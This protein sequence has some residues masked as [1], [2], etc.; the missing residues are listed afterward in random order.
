MRGLLGVLGAS[1]VTAKIYA[2]SI[3]ARFYA[4]WMVNCNNEKKERTLLGYHYI[5]PDSTTLSITTM[6][7]DSL[8]WPFMYVMPAI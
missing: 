8:H 5:T 1:Q 7:K 3:D 2:D 4:I 6:P